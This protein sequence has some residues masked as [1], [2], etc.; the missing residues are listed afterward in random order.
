MATKSFAG[1]GPVRQVIEE[2]YAHIEQLYHQLHMNP[3]VAYNEKDTSALIAG[4]LKSLGFDVTTGVGGYGVVGV[5]NNGKG[6][7]AMIRTDMDAL[8]IQEE[9]G[10]SYQSR[11]P[12]VMH[13]CGH[14]VHMGMFMGA[15][16]ALTQLK[17]KWHGTLVMVAQPAEEVGEGARAMLDAG[18]FKKFPKPDYALAMHVAGLDP[19]GTIGYHKGYSLANVDYVDITVY[20]KGGHGAMPHTTVDPIVTA[21]QIVMALQTLVSREQNPI[22]PAVVTVGSINGGTKYNI[23]PEEVRM[24]LT[25]RSFSDESRAHIK[26]GII[27]IAENIA[28]AARAPKPKVEYKEGVVSL[29]NDPKLVDELIPVFEKVVGPK[30]LSESKKEMYGEDFSYYGYK[31]GVPIFIFWVGS[32]PKGKKAGPAMHSPRFIPQFEETFRTGAQAMTEAV[33][34]L[35]NRK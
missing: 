7:T 1:E 26:E 29:Y 19:V 12:G 5:L 9:T 21:S 22:D 13:A 16:Y 20:G 14:D 25:V 28:A 32:Q 4:E 24:Q 11:N 2:R 34:K 15:A 18:L 10:L 27:R 17:D 31:T 6:P 35:Q 23:I 33:L 30:N 3:E 8:P